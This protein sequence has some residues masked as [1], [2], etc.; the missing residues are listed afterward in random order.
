MRSISASANFCCCSQ[1]LQKGDHGVALLLGLAE[2]LA[3]LA[4][5]QLA[6]AFVLRQGNAIGERLEIVF[7]FVQRAGVGWRLH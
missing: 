6:G 3:D 1:C 4:K 5:N 2:R 7:E